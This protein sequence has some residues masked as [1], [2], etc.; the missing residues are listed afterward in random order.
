MQSK[1]VLSLALFSSIAIASQETVEQSDKWY[2][3]GLSHYVRSKEDGNFIAQLI[4]VGKNSSVVTFYELGNVCFGDSNDRKRV[5]VFHQWLNFSKKCLGGK[6]YWVPS[7][8]QGIDYVSRKFSSYSD[9]EILFGNSDYTFST[10]YFPSV[11][12]RWE[13]TLKKSG[14]AL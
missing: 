7:S 1:I 3:E 9:V 14:N 6:E 13:K 2:V 11:R 8:Q 4:S 5:K 12:Q 10:K